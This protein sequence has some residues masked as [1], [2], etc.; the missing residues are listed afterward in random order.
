MSAPAGNIRSVWASAL[1]LA[2]AAD[3]DY[4]PDVLSRAPRVLSGE[5]PSEID[6]AD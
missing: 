4:R 1:M 2:A 3:L 6:P 5:E